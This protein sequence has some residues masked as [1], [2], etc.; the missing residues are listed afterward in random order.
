ME[1]W[2]VWPGVRMGAG[3]VMRD[4][5]LFD[6]VVVAPGA[7]IFGALLDK[8][9]RV[10]EGARIGEASLVEGAITVIPKGCHVSAGETI[11]AGA[12]LE[13]AVHP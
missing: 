7:H 9:V 5:I 11:E 4:S 2:G 10:G 3:G 12:N 6:D 8:D 1:G 13:A